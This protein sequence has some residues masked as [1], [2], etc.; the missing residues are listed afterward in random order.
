MWPYWFP[1]PILVIGSQAGERVRRSIYNWTTIREAWLSIQRDPEAPYKD[2]TAPAR[3]W[4]E[5]LHEGIDMQ[6]AEERGQTS[7]AGGEGQGKKSVERALFMASFRARF[8]LRKLHADKPPLWYNRALPDPA[9][10]IANPL[11]DVPMRQVVWD[12][13]ELGFRAELLALDKHFFPLQ[14]GRFGDRLVRDILVRNVFNTEELFGMHGI[15]ETPLGLAAS[16][17]SERAEA[18]EALRKLM[19]D[20]PDVPGTISSVRTLTALAPAE[21]IVDTERAMARFYCQTFYRIS[22]RAP[23]LPRIPPPRAADA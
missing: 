19:L 7:L 22:G 18:L 12:L 1:E 8:E 4:R 21:V 13:Y 5:L 3:V 20:W 23:V 11:V 14:A 2:R 9:P 17:P 6:G 15:P 10:D 16:R